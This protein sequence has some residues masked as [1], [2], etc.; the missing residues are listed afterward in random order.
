MKFVGPHQA[1]QEIPR[2]G[3]PEFVA[4]RI[5]RTWFSH[6][7]FSPCINQAKRLRLEMREKQSASPKPH[8]SATG[9]RH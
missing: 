7:L 6:T 4:G 3:A 9:A 8:R 1:P 5:P 2:Y